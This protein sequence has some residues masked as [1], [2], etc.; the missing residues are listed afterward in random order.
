MYKEFTTFNRSVKDDLQEI[1]YLKI[2]NN[3]P[4]WC[5]KGIPGLG[6]A[7]AGSNTAGAGSA[8]GAAGSA[9]GGGKGGGAG[10]VTLAQIGE[11]LETSQQLLQKGSTK[12]QNL[13]ARQK[14]LLLNESQ[15]RN[16]RVK[17][18]EQ[19]RKLEQQQ[20]RELA[21]QQM[22]KK[23]LEKNKT[24]NNNNNKLT[25]PGGGNLNVVVNENNLN[26]N[27]VNA[28]FL[29][30]TSS[31][32]EI[33]NVNNVNNQGSSS[34][35]AS[36][37][38]DKQSGDAG[39]DMHMQMSATTTGGSNL[40]G[41]GAVNKNS[42]PG[43]GMI[44]R[45]VSTVGNSVNAN[46]NPTHHSTITKLGSISKKRE[47]ELNYKD[48]LD[49]D[50]NYKDKVDYKDKKDYKR[51]NVFGHSYSNLLN[52]NLF[53]NANII[54]LYYNGG[55]GGNIVGGK[56]QGGNIL[57]GKGQVAKLALLQNE[58][59]IA[60]SE[61]ILE[62]Q[63]MK[64]SNMTKC[65]YKL[66]NILSLCQFL[67]G[68]WKLV[69]DISQKIGLHGPPYRGGG[70]FTIGVL[71]ALHLPTIEQEYLNLTERYRLAEEYLLVHPFQVRYLH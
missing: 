7:G 6:T 10:G 46:N 60:H 21:L 28:S 33:E 2:V 34:S 38:F 23:Q 62:M 61:R 58:K 52:E 56:G 37:G 29:T 44:S 17:L 9:G 31:N 51:K 26:V 19:Q 57:G 65:E 70:W 4:V 3:Q 22:G 45:R 30:A 12:L 25:T 1:L 32:I 13:Q 8:A 63:K 43:S 50:K 15:L 11:Q 18:Q 68:V 27:N 53:G 67:G 54:T 40:L 66:R 59:T 36:L 41:L 47:R 42:G 14:F 64:I 5:N 35:A 55:G 48:K 24:R 71:S 20:K 16:Q 49:K 39:G 69:L